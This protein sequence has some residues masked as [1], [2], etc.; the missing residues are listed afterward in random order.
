MESSQT[1][2]A[3]IALRGKPVTANYVKMFYSF[4]SSEQFHVAAGF[5]SALASDASHVGL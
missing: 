4:G 5:G 3:H 1:K 2:Q